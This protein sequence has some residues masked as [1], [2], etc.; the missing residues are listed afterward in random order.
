MRRS[1]IIVAA[2]VALLLAACS[3]LQFSYNNAD[4]L[5]R[6]MA[7]DYFDLDGEQS[8]A[9]QARISRLHDW[10]RTNELPTYAAL[11]QAASER[12]TR[13]L[14]G[15]DADWAIQVLRSRYRLLTARAAQEA[16][17]ILATLT[18]GQ[19]M[20]LE[21]K[22]ANDEA[23]FVKEWLIGD[24]K[25]RERTRAKRMVERFEE[26][27]GDLSSEQRAR[28][29]RFVQAHPRWSQIRLQDRRRWQREAVALIKRYRNAAELAPRLSR[30]FSEPEAGR[31]DEYRRETRR[32]ETDL[33]ELV[34]ELSA[35]LSAEQ[36]SRV[37]RR[38]DRYAEDFRA[39][40]RARSFAGDQPRTSPGS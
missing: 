35:T 13:G 24:E 18:P 37:V 5:L 3:A 22:L 25:S 7:W 30:L 1:G 17:S 16:A 40:A 31:S 32:W 8:E 34:A 21:K 28:V 26:W 9:L 12:V 33:A 11:L 10:H 27:T 29:E 19:V 36:R 39:L 38:L 23:K 4:G 15:S 6:Y 14:T 2:A 20:A